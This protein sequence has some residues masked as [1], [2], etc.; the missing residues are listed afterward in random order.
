MTEEDLIQQA[1]R[2]S[3]AD[4]EAENPGQESNG[5]TVRNQPEDLRSSSRRTLHENDVDEEI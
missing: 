1:I 4:A 3:M 5:N 2:N